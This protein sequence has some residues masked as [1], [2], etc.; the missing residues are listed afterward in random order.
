MLGSCRRAFTPDRH[1]RFQ[2]RLDDRPHQ[3]QRRDGD[4]EVRLAGRSD[5]HLRHHLDRPLGTHRR[6]LLIP[7]GNVAI[8]LDGCPRT[9]P[10]D[11]HRQPSRRSSTTTL[12]A[13]A[14]P[15]AIT[16]AY[17]GYWLRCGERDLEPDGQQGRPDHLLVRPR[18]HHL[19]HAAGPAQL[20]ALVSV[21]GPDTTTGARAIRP[22]PGRSCSP[23]R[24][25]R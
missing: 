13:S 23:V 10:I 9:A 19:R 4:A 12:G 6:R 14:S 11:S 15:Y 18:G 16:Y 8:T 3:C 7:P 20:D 22:R 17:A 5:D 2:P 24:G 25:R 1:H 21:A